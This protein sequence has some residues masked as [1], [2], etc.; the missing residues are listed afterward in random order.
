MYT[1]TDLKGTGSLGQP[2]LPET[3]RSWNGSSSDAWSHHFAVISGEL[4]MNMGDFCLFY[5][6]FSRN[7]LIPQILVLL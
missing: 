7:H 6:V 4:L 1:Y 2:L 5:Y 3:W